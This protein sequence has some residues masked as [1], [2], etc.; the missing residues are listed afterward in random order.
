MMFRAAFALLVLVSLAACGNQDK[1]NFAPV[2]SRQSSNNPAAPPSPSSP[3]S[4]TKMVQVQKGDTLFSIARRHN[5]PLRALIDENGLRPPY[6]LAAGRSLR[7]P[8]QIFHKV[9]PGDTLYA[10]S[11]K[12][13]VDT[14]S[15]ARFNQLQPPFAVKVGQIIRVPSLTQ[16]GPGQMPATIAYAQNRSAVSAQAL[17]PPPGGSTSAAVKSP[18]QPPAPQVASQ[19]PS[20]TKPIAPEEKFDANRPNFRWPLSGKTLSRFGPKEN[21][22]HNDGLNLAA[23]KGTPVKAAA[24]GEV[25]YVGDELKAYGNLI[26]VRHPGGWMTA[27]AHIGEITVTRGQ[28]VKTGQVIG[29]VGQS[30]A[31]DR[32]QLHFEIRKGARAINP[33]TYLPK[34]LAD[35]LNPPQLAG[36]RSLGFSLKNRV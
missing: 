24:P 6:I 29:K 13:G 15:L 2:E 9:T 14:A 26:L 36:L 27:Y 34:T 17:P 18:T 20:Q 22:R 23:A 16:S 21:G 33:L 19:L 11:R 30:G 35:L 3:N 12:Y 7:L 25:A 5:V 4:P 8:N 28:K 32:P 31:V 10:I 1:K